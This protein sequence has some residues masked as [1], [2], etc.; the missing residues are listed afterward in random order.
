MDCIILAGNRDSYRDVSDKHNKALLDIDGRTILEII[1][2]ELARVDEI[3]RL[4][5][6]GPKAAL[7]N[8]LEPLQPNYPKPIQSFEQ[9]QDLV[10]NI[11]SVVD[12][13][14][15]GDPDRHVLILPSDVPLIIAEEIRE[16]IGKADMTRYDYVGGLATEEV[17]TRFYPTKD[18]PG[19]RMAYFYCQ[20][21][22]YRINNLH[23]VR[24]AAIHSIDYIRKTYAIRYQ[25]KLWNMLG[26][27]FS[28]LGLA[29]KIPGSL[30]VYPGLQLARI[31][32]AKGWH[33]AAS[34]IRPFLKVERIEYYFGRILETRMKI[35]TTSYGGS[36]IDVDNDRD[37]HAIRKRFQEWIEMQRALAP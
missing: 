31:W 36:T 30:L 25:K 35:I 20:D 28:L 27:F 10:E 8:V 12:R 14:G 24:P 17:L 9:K 2:T 37:Y 21:H 15:S 23:M 11:L 26:V 16:F 7:D 1:V 4:L 5:V 22:G 18:K 34:L 6:V 19:V 33:K 3:D 13:T 29:I 32:E